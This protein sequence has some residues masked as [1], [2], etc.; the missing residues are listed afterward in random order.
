M[1]ATPRPQRLSLHILILYAI[2]AC[3]F[4]AHLGD[5]RKNWRLSSEV[6]T[7]RSWDMRVATREIREALK[8]FQRTKNSDQLGARLAEIETSVRSRPIRG[9]ERGD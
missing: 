5:V 9:S 1:D 6:Q 3:L 8:T 2:L 4:F 7:L